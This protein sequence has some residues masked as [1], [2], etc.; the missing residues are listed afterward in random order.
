[1]KNIVLAVNPQ[2]CERI[3]SGEKTFEYR[4]SIPALPVGGIYIYETAPVSKVVGRV[5][6]EGIVSGTPSEVWKATKRGGCV[7]K[8][9]YDEYYRRRSKAYA[10]RLKDP[11]LFEKPLDLS[12]F[13]LS[14]PPQNFAYF[15][16]VVKVLPK[17]WYDPSEDEEW[18]S[19]LEDEKG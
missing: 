10:Y 6:V 18:L 12:F 17:E 16:N 4:K 7:D 1:M 9:F 8:A 13:G 14:S 11:Q 19:Y 3:F 5:L 15:D 2:W